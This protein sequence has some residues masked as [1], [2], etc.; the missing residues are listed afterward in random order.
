MTRPEDEEIDPKKLFGISLAQ[1][2]ELERKVRQQR[3]KK[4][5]KPQEH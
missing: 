1:R 5:K 3:K 2:K 4:P